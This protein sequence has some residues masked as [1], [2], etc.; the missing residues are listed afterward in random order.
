MTLRDTKRDAAQSRN[1][2]DKK[3]RN[4]GS[5]QSNTQAVR[6]TGSTRRRFQSSDP[7]KP[8]WK[9]DEA[10]GKREKAQRISS[11]RNE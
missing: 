4:P 1:L 2:K 10:R 11:E 7:R 6:A 3:E 5:K 8:P 9:R